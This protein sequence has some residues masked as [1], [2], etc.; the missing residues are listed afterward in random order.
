MTSPVSVGLDLFARILETTVSTSFVDQL[1]RKRKIEAA[2]GN[3]Q[4]DR[5][6]VADDLST[7]Q[8][9]KD[10]IFSGALSGARSV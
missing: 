4:P 2:P 6:G 8:Q 3:L 5:G 1:C 7:A 9:Q 10:I